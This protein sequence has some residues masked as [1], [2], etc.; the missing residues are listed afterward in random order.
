MTSRS[1]TSGEIRLIASLFGETVRTGPVRI[2]R[3]KWWFGQ[4]AM[5]TMAPDGH[6][7][8][9]QKS[10]AY[11][12]DFGAASVHMQAF[13]LHEITH[14]WQVQTGTN[15]LIARGLW[16][17]YDYLP[18]KAGRSYERYSIEAQA[19]IVRHYHLLRCGICVPGAGPISEYEKILPFLPRSADH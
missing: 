11:C 1:L 6:L 13:F 14:V 8:F 12:D 7:W 17:R 10:T 3:R 16:S 15:L 2:H 19:E 9:H 5:I 4:P 18:L